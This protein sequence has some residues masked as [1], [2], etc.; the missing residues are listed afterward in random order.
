MDKQPSTGSE[1]TRTFFQQHYSPLS[2]FVPSNYSPLYLLFFSYCVWEN[3]EA[4]LISLWNVNVDKYY[5]QLRK[6]NMPN[7]GTRML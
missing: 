6:Q 2:T 1:E 7:V 4:A 3:E 5:K